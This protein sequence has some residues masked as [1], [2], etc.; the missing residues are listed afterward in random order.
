M[1]NGMELLSQEKIKT[2]GIKSSYKCIGILQVDTIKQVE[3]KEK[4]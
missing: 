4:F 3:M 1:T 2:F